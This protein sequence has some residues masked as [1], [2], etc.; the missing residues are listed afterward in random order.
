[1]VLGL[2]MVRTTHRHE[3]VERT[4]DLSTW[5]RSE[6]ADALLLARSH[7]DHARLGNRLAAVGWAAAEHGQ[8]NR[9]N[10]LLVRD[11]Q[12]VFV[13][14]QTDIDARPRYTNSPTVPD[15]V[16][17]LSCLNVL[18]GATRGGPIVCRQS[19]HALGATPGRGRSFFADAGRKVGH[20]W[21]EFSRT[22]GTRSGVTPG[23]GASER[24][25][26]V[27]AEPFAGRDHW[28]AED[29]AR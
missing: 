21:K 8:A 10:T 9:R 24:F 3:R 23:P 17:A 29:V 5:P 19:G 22:L 26:G 6:E 14:V 7:G 28:L 13:S 18:E 20:R 16:N 11:D 25:V 1:M 27:G 2:S 12:S 4:V 15:R